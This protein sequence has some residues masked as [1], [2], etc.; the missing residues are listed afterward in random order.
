MTASEQPVGNPQPGEASPPPS[1]VRPSVAAGTARTRP[2]KF[3]RSALS[4]LLWGVKHLPCTILFGSV[5]GC[6]SG[7]TLGIIAALVGLWLDTTYGENDQ[8]RFRPPSSPDAATPGHPLHGS[9]HPGGHPSPA[10]EP[11]SPRSRWIREEQQENHR[12]APD[13]PFMADAQ[14]FRPSRLEWQ[15][16][17]KGRSLRF[18]FDPAPGPGH[19][20]LVFAFPQGFPP[21]EGSDPRSFYGRCLPVKGR[22]AELYVP[23]GEIALPDADWPVEVQVA[24]AKGTNVENPGPVVAQAGWTIPWRSMPYD[25]FVVFR[26]LVRMALLL[27]GVDGPL[28][29]AE[30]RCIKEWFARVAAGHPEGLEPLRRVMKE[31][32]HESLER[33]VDQLRFRWAG[34]TDSDELRRTTTSF[35][36][37]VAAADGSI[38]FREADL[39]ERVVRALGGTDAEWSDLVAQYQLPRGRPWEVLGLGPNA[40]REEIRAAWKALVLQNHPDRFADA[41]D[42]QQAE[43]HRRMAE[44]NEAYEAMMREATE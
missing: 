10:P 18:L 40:T 9:G 2:W 43:R 22:R 14:R 1:H 38:R 5:A 13:A 27:S 33:L 4:G 26:P 31:S 29:R 11:S 7:A 16:D 41:P 37:S 28:N 30:V 44:I 24:V 32:G 25:P 6:H 36:L 19:L 34:P 20:L 39:I 21:A 23:F 12:D 15:D 3:A 17:E 35:L 8:Q 42:E